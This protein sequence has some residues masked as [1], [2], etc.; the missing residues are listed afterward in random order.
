MKKLQEK[1]L[2]EEPVEDTL[3][4]VE[5][6]GPITDVELEDAVDEVEPEIEEDAFSSLLTD[7]IA[8]NYSSIDRYKSI[9]VT[10][11]ASDL[12]ASVKESISK[13]ISDIID[14]KTIEIGML[15]TALEQ[16]NP[17]MIELIDDGAEYADSVVEEK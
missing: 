7:E 17:D 11:D 14:N 12:D 10:L 2:L 6:T 9:K 8:N 16:V 13:I 5:I 4:A 3:P 15:Q 1:I